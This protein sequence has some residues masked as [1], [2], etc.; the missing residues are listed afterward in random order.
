MTKWPKITIAIP[1]FNEARHID[2]CLKSIFK[3]KYPGELEIFIIDDNST[4][5]TLVKVKK[6]PVK[7]LTN[8]RKDL[9]Y[10]KKL[11]LDNA[12]GEYF[13][14][15][16]AD[17]QLLGP[18]WFNKMIDPLL[19][20]KSIIASFTKYVSTSSD[21]PLNKYIT[22]DFLQR[23]PL[24]IWLTPPLEQVVVGRKKHW[25]IC[26]YTLEKML[27]TGLCVYRRK[28]LIKVI[29]KR[30]KFVELDVVVLLVKNRHS[31]FAYVSNAGM[32]HPFITSL[33]ELTSK[34]SRNLHKMYFNQPDTREWTWVNWR[35]PF[36]FLKLLIWIIYANSLVFPTIAG[37]IK[38]IRYKTWVGL[39]EP[40]FVWITT[41]LILFTFLT[42]PEGR[43]MITQAFI[44]DRKKN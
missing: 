28:E 8:S 35:N 31:R 12:T 33:S 38:S 21:S 44:W 1:T 5:D 14:Y 43:K 30:S 17:I 22:L 2:D 7:V 10:G 25:T 15:L 40:V 37:L 11:G 19:A 20:D 23:D 16:D 32:H 27:P 26:N 13:M 36:H 24:F 29:G 39:Y 6:Y 42:V 34:R 4:D 41:N 3:Q 18:F 9:L